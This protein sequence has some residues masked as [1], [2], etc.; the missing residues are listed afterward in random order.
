MVFCEDEVAETLDCARRLERRTLAVRS[1]LIINIL[2]SFFLTGPWG[3]LLFGSWLHASTGAPV[4]LRLL[5][6]WWLSAIVW[7]PLSLI[8]SC[9]TR[10]RSMVAFGM[11][12]LVLAGA[13]IY[14]F[15]GPDA[16]PLP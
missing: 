12:N 4:N 3:L 2:C 1:A 10:K 5:F 6:V 8:M 14:A 9:L 13:N 16:S 15:V 11:V 7:G